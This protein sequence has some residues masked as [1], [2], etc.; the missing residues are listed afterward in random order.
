VR[1]NSACIQYGAV[2]AILIP[3]S[4]AH[5]LSDHH[6]NSLHVRLQARAISL[7]EV[8]IAAF[9][10]EYRGRDQAF[11]PAESGAPTA[12]R[13]PQN[14]QQD[15]EARKNWQQGMQARKSAAAAASRSNS[16]TGCEPTI[17]VQPNTGAVHSNGVG[18][19]PLM[20]PGVMVGSV[21]D[22]IATPL[23]PAPSSVSVAAPQSL[24]LTDLSTGASK[25][26][27][28]AST[29][30]PTGYQLA[31]NTMSSANGG[32]T[33]KQDTTTKPDTAL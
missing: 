16:T 26:D 23:A 11:H 12:A 28:G 30:S 27:Q 20:P 7:S 6:M 24:E 32:A 9:A 22:S 14:W 5:S 25:P 15:M 33:T 29:S 3:C 18:S 17:S 13:L 4:C 8:P 31:I 2:D 19:T 10:G 1:A 21:A